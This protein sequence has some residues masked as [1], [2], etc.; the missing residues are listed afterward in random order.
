MSSQDKTLSQILHALDNISPGASDDLKS[1]IYKIKKQGSGTVAFNL[2]LSD[3]TKLDLVK[4]LVNSALVVVMDQ[5]KIGGGILNTL[6]LADAEITSPNVFSDGAKSKQ[7]RDLLRIVIP[8]SE[9]GD[10]SSFKTAS[11]SASG[12]KDIDENQLQTALEQAISSD[13]AFDIQSLITGISNPATIAL[14]AVENSPKLDSGIVAAAQ[15]TLDHVPSVIKVNDQILTV[16]TPSDNSLK[17]TIGSDI[18]NSAKNTVEQIKAAGPPPAPP[19]PPT[20]SSKPYFG[21]K[22]IKNLRTSPARFYESIGLGAKEPKLESSPPVAPPQPP[23]SSNISYNYLLKPLKTSSGIGQKFFD[24]ARDSSLESQGTGANVGFFGRLLGSSPS[25][26]APPPPP[27]PPS[28]V[29]PASYS[30]SMSSRNWEPL[31][32]EQPMI[33]RKRKSSNKRKASVKRKLSS[34]RKSSIKRKSSNKR[35]ASGKSKVR[36]CAPGHVRNQQTKRCRSKVRK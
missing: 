7:V 27:P 2:K 16:E 33:P 20:T 10:I 29:S 28:P 9:I 36:A 34:K 4:Q 30:S 22:F 19:Q 8:S 14:K 25:S 15:G 13:K 35:K 12:N 31:F 1:F 24:R 17:I 32:K 23:K 26:P 11:V 6:G 21:N 3:P 18:T 5:N